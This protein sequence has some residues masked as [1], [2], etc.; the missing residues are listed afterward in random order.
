MVD[1][2]PSGNT[3]TGDVLGIWPTDPL[4]PGE[5]VLRLT[6]ETNDGRTAEQSVRV[7]VGG[8]PVTWTPTTPITATLTA[9]T[10][11]TI[12]PSPAPPQAPSFWQRL[13][14]GP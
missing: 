5:Y 1:G 8:G 11:P 6:V 7:V 12:T 13:F 14:G 9:T 10:A 3:V 4:A 2:S